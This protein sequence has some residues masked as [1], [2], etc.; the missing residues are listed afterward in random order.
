[1]AANAKSLPLLAII[2]LWRLPHNIYLQCLHSSVSPISLSSW[3]PS[4]A[5]WFLIACWVRV[6]LTLE[7]Q[8]LHSTVSHHL[9]YSRVFIIPD[10]SFLA[11]SFLLRPV[12]RWARWARRP[13]RRWARNIWDFTRVRIPIFPALNLPFW[14]NN[15]C[16]VPPHASYIG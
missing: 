13:V 8:C 4:L 1:M 3:P 16:Q 6:I 5:S 15:W 9:S 14:S 2:S 11:D 12:R 10:P 7:D